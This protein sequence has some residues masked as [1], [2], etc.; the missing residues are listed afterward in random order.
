MSDHDLQIPEFLRTLRAELNDAI[1]VAEAES[2]QFDL[3][4]TEV[5]IRVQVTKAVEGGAGIKIWVVE[6]GADGKY[7][8]STSHTVRLK[9]VP[10]IDGKSPKVSSRSS[11]SPK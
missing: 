1:Q 4:E 11:H 8:R 10:K 2:L 5:E 9:L 3:V 7:E 6:A